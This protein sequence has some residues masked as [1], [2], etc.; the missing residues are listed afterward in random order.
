MA[1]VKIGIYLL[2]TDDI[3]GM[4][5]DCNGSIYSVPQYATTLDLSEKQRL[6]LELGMLKIGLC[7]VCNKIHFITE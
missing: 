1:K 6:Q 2:D 3:I 4:C 7:P 5:P